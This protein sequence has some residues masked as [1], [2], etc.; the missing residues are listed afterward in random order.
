MART[1]HLLGAVRS[2]GV[3]AARTYSDRMTDSDSEW[4][5]ALAG[6]TD[7]GRASSPRVRGHRSVRSSDTSPVWLMAVSIVCM[8][9]GMLIFA[10]GD[11]VL[12]AIGLAVV[13]AF[14]MIG[15]VGVVAEG[16]VLGS[17]RIDRDR[18]HRSW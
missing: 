11:G 13:A 17:R 1:S 6:F 5:D 18:A 2:L 9:C 7:R 4:V 12:S 15:L 8:V 3:V 14:T 10:L 16:V